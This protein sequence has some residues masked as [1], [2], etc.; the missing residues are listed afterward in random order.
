MRT[1]FTHLTNTL[2]ETNFFMDQKKT[3]KTF[4]SFEI[5][6]TYINFQYYQVNAIWSLSYGTKT[7]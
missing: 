7:S 6:Q 1:F 3:K 5:N 2:W 4:K